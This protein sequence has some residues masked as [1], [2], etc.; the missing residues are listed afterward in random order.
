MV[1]HPCDNTPSM[2]FYP[3]VRKGSSCSILLHQKG[4]WLMDS[5]DNIVV[6]EAEK[7]DMEK[8]KVFAILAYI[9]FF[10]PLLAAKESRFAMYHANQGLVLF[11][12]VLAINVIGWIIPVIGF[13]LTPLGN[14][15]GFVLAIIGIVNAANGRKKPLPFIGSIELIK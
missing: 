2:V 3:G 1:D 6:S 5:D 9:I 12:G 7:E 8:N 14:L 4:C 10:I 11:L 13:V 15:C